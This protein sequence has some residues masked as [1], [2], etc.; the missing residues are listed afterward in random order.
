MYK[1]ATMLRKHLENAKKISSQNPDH[2][3]LFF[4]N[5]Q[6]HTSTGKIAESVT[7]L[8]GRS[9]DKELPCS[10]L[11]YIVDSLNAVFNIAHFHPFDHFKIN[12]YDDYWLRHMGNARERCEG[13]SLDQGLVSSYKEFVMFQRKLTPEEVVTN[14]DWCIQATLLLGYLMWLS[15]K[16]PD[17]PN[18]KLIEL[19]TEKQ[20]VRFF[21]DLDKTWTVQL[22]QW[23]SA[24]DA[25]FSRIQST[26]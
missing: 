21:A 7:V 23:Q 8:M 10:P 25:L 17:K 2:Y 12:G 9:I 19:H 1:I 16:H 3:T 5:L 22:E 24:Q 6:N 13:L 26:L 4:A 14:G 20:L 18:C 15:Y 11:T